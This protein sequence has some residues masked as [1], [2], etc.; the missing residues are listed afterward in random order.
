M[1]AARPHRLLRWLRLAL[2]LVPVAALLVGTINWWMLSRSRSR[3]YPDKAALPANQVGVV[4]GTSP[5]RVGG[6]PNPF[7]ENRMDAAAALYRAGKVKHLLLSGDNGTRDYDEPAAMRQALVRRGVPAS[8][9]TLDDAGF[10]TLDTM[11]R[12]ARVFG[13]ARATIITDDFHEPRALFLAQSFGVDAV[14]Y[15]S[16]PVPFRY[17]K[18]T[19]F[20]EVASRVVAWLD[21]RVLH[22]QPHFDGPSEAIRI[23]G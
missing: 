6:Q 23:A 22:T 8:A 7:F 12:A 2:S 14:G 16:E 17:S 5:L 4:L 3:L 9:T 21:V 20:R 1:P 18:K 11:A 13:L 19:R 15:P 10:R